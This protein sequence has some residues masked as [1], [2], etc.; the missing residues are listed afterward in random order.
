MDQWLTILSGVLA[1]LL[2]AGVGAFARHRLWLTQEAD[3]SMLSLI[4]RVLMPCLVADTIIGNE[5]LREPLRVAMPP[6]I[7]FGLLVVSFAVVR[8][9]LVAGGK[10]ANLVTPA[11][12]RTFTLT[13]GLQN[14]G[15]LPVPLTQLLFDKTTMGLLLLHNVGVEIG[16]WTVGLAVLTGRLGKDWWKGFVNPITI[17]IVLS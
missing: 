13:T 15:Y 10:W 1:V 8:L 6:L 3:K 7:G 11:Q 5:A 16:L 12:K 9:L 17:A 4:L 14:Y 2:I